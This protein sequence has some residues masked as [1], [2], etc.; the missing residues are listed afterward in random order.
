M[1]KLWVCSGKAIL[2]YYKSIEFVFPVKNVAFFAPP[3]L[4]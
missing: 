2:F 1:K 3:P 4:S